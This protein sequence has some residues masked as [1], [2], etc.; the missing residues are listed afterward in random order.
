MSGAK[1]PDLGELTGRRVRFAFRICL[2]V[3]VNGDWVKV[4]ADIFSVDGV[5]NISPDALLREG[6]PR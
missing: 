6:C 1:F 2:G 3:R 5:W 4:R